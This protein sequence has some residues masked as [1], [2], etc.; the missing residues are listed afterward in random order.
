MSGWGL[1]E[2]GCLR[3]SH[4]QTD[5][6][7]AVLC[8]ILAACAL[9]GARG[10]GAPNIILIMTDDAGFSD[11]GFQDQV[12]W[13]TTAVEDFGWGDYFKITSTP[14]INSIAA[15]G[16]ICTDAYVTAA[17]CAPSR[18]GF[19]TGRYQQRFGYEN[20]RGE[21]IPKTE[22]ILSE[23]LKELGYA[24]FCVGKWHLSPSS[25]SQFHPLES[26]F[27]HFFG[28]LR[29]DRSFVKME[30][31]DSGKALQRDGVVVPESYLDGIEG[32][33]ITDAFGIE[34]ARYIEDHVTAGTGDPFFLYL[35]FHAPHIPMAVNQERYEDESLAGIPVPFD[36]G[37][38]TMAGL[39]KAVDDNV[40]RVL[41]TLSEHGLT[42]NTLIVL[43]NDNGGTHSGRTSNW[44]VYGWKNYLTDGGVRVPWVMQWPGR[45][46]AG[47]TY[48]G[49]IS[50]LDL[51]P[52]FVAAAGGQVPADRQLDGVDVVPFVNGTNPGPPREAL[53][54]RVGGEAAEVTAMRYGTWKL[55]REDRLGQGREYGT[56]STV[57]HRGNQVRVRLSDLELSETDWTNKTEANPAVVA[58]MLDM[59]AGWENTVLAPY[60][61]TGQIRTIGGT[62]A[63]SRLGY[64][65]TA[66]P[67]QVA[68]AFHTL[69]NPLST[70]RSWALGLTMEVEANTDGDAAGYLVLSQGSSLWTSLRIGLSEQD[71]LTIIE[72][73]GNHVTSAP[74]L[75]E[76]FPEGQ[77]AFEVAYDETSRTLVLYYGRDSVSH[78]LVGTAIPHFDH[79]GVGVNKS[80]AAFSPVARMDTMSGVIDSL[81]IVGPGLLALEARFN[82]P[83]LSHLTI[84]Y[85]AHLP[86]WGDVFELNL[87]EYDPYR[88]GEGRYRVVLPFNPEAGG[89]Y[90]VVG[91]Q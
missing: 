23:Y 13:N 48:E 36:S 47:T 33:I 49:M 14:R 87:A 91:R 56:W 55:L 86:D 57:T 18:A 79:A 20:N 25:Y 31:P 10:A 66:H 53:F 65:L 83:V 26:G 1:P 6:M 61:G 52:T 8:F 17:N 78:T 67:L 24:T 46:P 42:D 69:R 15:N 68:S 81:E 22:K 88:I 77:A 28:F 50:T 54:W 58:R 75:F 82:R 43:T 59:L 74:L 19:L 29:G 63:T 40:G 64:Q 4:R 32:G 30:N 5:P 21:G 85:S 27:D 38:R 2:A 11:F 80:E 70:S 35:S 12:S 51:L 39:M 71:G 16:V 44:P 9:G 76:P 3:R 89:Y 60:W 34:A 41:D 73:P 37:R 45:I 90:R 72:N 84:Q 62:L 7:K